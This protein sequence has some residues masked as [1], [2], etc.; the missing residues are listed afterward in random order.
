MRA[1]LDLQ[2]ACNDLQRAA[3]M[4]ARAA[5]DEAKAAGAL[6]AAAAELPRGI[7][8]RDPRSIRIADVL[9]G[10]AIAIL[11]RHT[12][13]RTLGDLEKWGER[14]LRRVP[15]LGETCLADVKTVLQSRGLDLAEDR[16]ALPEDSRRAP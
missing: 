4:F 9:S 12:F 8:H 7:L 10:R 5:R 6:N 11:S 15:G 13:V 14:A 2:R 16:D 1:T 3:Q